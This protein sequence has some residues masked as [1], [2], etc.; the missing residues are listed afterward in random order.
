MQLHIPRDR[1]VQLMN[2]FQF[3]SSAF[4]DAVRDLIDTN[5]PLTGLQS[6]SSRSAVPERAR[7]RITTASSALSLPDSAV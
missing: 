4:P 3:L 2:V 6:K 7:R 1:P 5:K